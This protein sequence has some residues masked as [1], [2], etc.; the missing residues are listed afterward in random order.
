MPS[1]KVFK[2]HVRS[3]SFCA[4]F[5]VVR[6]G[7]GNLRHLTMRLWCIHYGEETQNTRG[8]EERVIRDEEGTIISQRKINNTRVAR[9][10]CQ[11]KILSSREYYNAIRSQ[12]ANKTEA[13]LITGLV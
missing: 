2:D 4:G 5:D 6:K 9:L 8:L 1:L 7:G 11:F 10:G 12:P 13:K 3:Y